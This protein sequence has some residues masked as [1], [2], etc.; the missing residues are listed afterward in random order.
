M[1]GWP[2]HFA[3]SQNR[4]KKRKK[5]A[6]VRFF[7]KCD[8]QQK[9]GFRF[10]GFCWKR[11]YNQKKGFQKLDTGV[12]VVIFFNFDLWQYRQRACQQNKMTQQR[13]TQPK[14][15][16]MRVFWF[17]WIISLLFFLLQDRVKVLV[18]KLVAWLRPQQQQDCCYCC[19]Y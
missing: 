15:I 1:V 6:Q 9:I 14:N 3:K 2:Q 18:Y 12:V 17:V 19:Y 7:F 13:T 10:F 16:S 8:T 11:I 4:K 5:N